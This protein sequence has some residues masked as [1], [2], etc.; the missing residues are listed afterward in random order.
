MVIDPTGKVKSAQVVES[1]LERPATARCVRATV[2]S[3]R[4]PQFSGAPI[5]VRLPFRL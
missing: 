2:A 1:T 5:P 3:F 4:F